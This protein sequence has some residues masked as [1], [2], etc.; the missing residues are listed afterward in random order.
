MIK[1]SQVKPNPE[2]PRF[3]KD[4]KFERLVQS[5]VLF[6]QMMAI[7][8]IVVD[9]NWISLGGNM[10][11]RACIEIQ[12]RGDLFAKKILEASPKHSPDQV[13][14]FLI[15]L[16]PLFKGFFP[17]GWVK[18]E[19]GLTE[20]QKREFIIKDNAAFG[21]WDFDM[22]ANEWDAEDLQEWGIDLPFH[23][24]DKEEEEPEEKTYTPTFKFEVEC[25]TEAERNK[26]MAELLGRGYMCTDDY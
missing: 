19:K 4:D 10:R 13:V 16:S 21:Q 6:P 2:N 7:R 15:T 12:N 11:D 9:E 8:P 14:D 3:I 26:L 24:D 5:I 17:D 20:E 1:L 18:Q 22:L 25:K 23:G